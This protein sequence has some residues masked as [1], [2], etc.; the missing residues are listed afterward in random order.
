MQLNHYYMRKETKS[1]IHHIVTE[2]EK[3]IQN[4]NAVKGVI[5]QLSLTW[6]ES[7]KEEKK[8]RYVNTG[9]KVLNK[10]ISPEKWWEEEEMGIIPLGSKRNFFST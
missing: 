6:N 7:I 2:M 3:I 1:Y 10:L 4:F 5:F 9:G 8:Q